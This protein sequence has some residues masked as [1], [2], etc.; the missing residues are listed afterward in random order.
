MTI[1]MCSAPAA[2]ISPCEFREAI[3]GTDLVRGSDGRLLEHVEPLARRQSV[4]LDLSSVERIDAAGIAALVALYTAA[5][6]A[7][8]S[9]IVFNAQARVAEVLALVGLDRILL[10]R[11]PVQN[12]NSSSTLLRPAA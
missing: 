6:D 7:G 1:A 12:G 4:A 5:R 11:G 9:F 2:A 10:S 8:H 3:K